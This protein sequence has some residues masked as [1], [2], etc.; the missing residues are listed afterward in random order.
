MVVK[1]I[2]P[3]KIIEKARLKFISRAFLYIEVGHLN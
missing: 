1:S 3:I 2:K